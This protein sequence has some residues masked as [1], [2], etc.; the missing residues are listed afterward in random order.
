MNSFL[1]GHIPAHE[2]L[3]EIQALR[4]GDSQA[5]ERLGKVLWDP[6][7]LA[8][9]RMLGD[10]FLE[11]DDVTQDSLLAVLEYFQRDSAFQGDPVKLAVTIA[12]NRCIDI[13]RKRANNPEV[14]LTPMSNWIADPSSSALDDLEQNEL[15]SQLQKALDQISDSCGRLLRSLYLEKTPTDQIRQQLGLKSV[16]AVYYR[17]EICLQEAKKF[18]QRGLVF[19]SGSNDDQKTGKGDVSEVKE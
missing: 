8:V 16:H 10:E 17:R 19:R 3:V 2:L 14:A 12:R 15:H 6:I 11:K 4:Q 18:L 9:V 5:A 1:P 13:L 7:H